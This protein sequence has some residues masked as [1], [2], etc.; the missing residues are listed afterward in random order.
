MGTRE[1]KSFSK[2]GAEEA[3]AGEGEPELGAGPEAF[4]SRGGP[5]FD[6]QSTQGPP[7]VCL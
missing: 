2:A 7:R 3:Q 6:P 1:G 4:L 5:T